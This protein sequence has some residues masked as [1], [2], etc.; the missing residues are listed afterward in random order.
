M[1]TT[2]FVFVHGNGTPHWSLGWAPWLKA[3]LER[4]GY[5]TFFETMPDSI[6]GRAEYWLP[7]LEN[8]VGVGEHDVI[9]GWSTGAVAAM[10]FAEVNK[11]KGSILVSPSYTDL[12][13][14]LEKQSGYFIIP[15]QWEKIV[16]NQGNIA[17]V[18]GDDDPYIPQEQ[19]DFI[20]SKLDPT[21]IK[22]ANGKH[23][24]ERTEFPELLA[25]IHSTY[26]TTAEW[27]L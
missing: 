1:N 12:D 3:Q 23:F 7:F 26:G 15:W 25:Y 24:M 4:A 14:E 10:R 8:Y 17:L 18:W 11:L 9:I 2:R 6:I 21:C 5:E 20:A 19:F 13:E 27:L 22:V 16:A